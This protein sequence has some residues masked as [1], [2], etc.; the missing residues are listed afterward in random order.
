MRIGSRTI[1]LG[2]ASARE[3]AIAEGEERACTAAGCC[4]GDNGARARARAQVCARLLSRVRPDPF[5]F[6]QQGSA[7]AV[8]WPGCTV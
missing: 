7:R 6:V 4:E 5:L 2:G 1:S 8:Q 3:E